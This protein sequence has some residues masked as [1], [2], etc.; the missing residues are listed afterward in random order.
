ML[1]GVNDRYEQALALAE[2]L[3]PRRDLQGQP[4]PV[5]P[6][7]LDV[8]RARAA[9]RSRAF[10]DALEEH[11]VPATIRLTRGRDIDAACGQLAAQAPERREPPASPRRARRACGRTPRIA[12]ARGQT[13]ASPTSA[14][15]R[16]G[17]P[18]VVARRCDRE[19]RLHRAAL[20]RTPVG[21]RSDRRARRTAVDA[22]VQRRPEPP[23]RRRQRLIV[24]DH[25]L[26]TC[27]P[28]RPPTSTDPRARARSRPADHRVVDP[29][30]RPRQDARRPRA[31]RT[32]CTRHREAQLAGCSTRTDRDSASGDRG[33]R[34]GRG[35]ATR[36]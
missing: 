20:R 2:L 16:D 32:R 22:R 3:G 5:Q 10:R 35:S 24:R 29:G 34:S 14:P 33:A 6:D 7:R 23:A 17:R 31:S 11:G 12:P 18:V 15:G 1:A 8:R 27:P 30:H 4:D 9:R 36:R 19:G 21:H 26:R 25:G 28:Q 13:A